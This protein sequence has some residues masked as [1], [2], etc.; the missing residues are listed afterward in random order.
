MGDGLCVFAF[1]TRDRDPVPLS[2]LV[3]RV[4]I[5]SHCRI[6]VSS[7]KEVT[8][9]KLVAVIKVADVGNVVV[10]VKERWLPQK[11]WLQP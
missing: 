2:H 4:R 6:L 3:L 9:I 11:K 5:L 7:N 1:S 10:A 8:A